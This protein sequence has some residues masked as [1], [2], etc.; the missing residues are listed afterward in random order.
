MP[1]ART[2][3]VL[4]LLSPPLLAQTACSSGPPVPRP[5]VPG[6]TSDRR[7]PD[8]PRYPL[9][10][11]G[12]PVRWAEIQPVLAEIAGD[13]AVQEII[14][15]RVLDREA[16]ARG[17]EITE[18]DL[19]TERARLAQIARAD[20]VA[21]L[22]ALLRARGLGPTRLGALLRRN[23]ILRRL[24]DAPEPTP[25]QIE[26]DLAIRYGPSARA[27]VIITT[28]ERDGASARSEA[29]QNPAGP[30]AG[31]AEAAMAWSVDPSA[32]A[33]GLVP[34]ARPADP[35]WAATIAEQLRTL[36]LNE[37]GPLVAFQ[38]GFA[39]VL[40]ESRIPPR[41]PTMDERAAAAAARAQQLE[42]DAMRDLAQRLARSADAAVL[43]PALHWKSQRRSAP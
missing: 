5:T 14:L 15:N 19:D 22:D 40:V 16:R 9:L 29:I 10:V 4:L 28:T 24:V 18:A 39:I 3:A 2:L 6:T 12:S 7:T 33:G 25:A 37:I 26:Q 32:A 23:A 8:E 35:R 13:Q 11:N 20:G 36:P 38:G 31:M 34:D 1:R 21:E 43:D 27:R 42:L 30:I 17:L 41:T